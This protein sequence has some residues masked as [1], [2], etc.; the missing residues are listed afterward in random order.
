M[1]SVCITDVQAI[2]GIEDETAGDAGGDNMHLDV[3]RRL[4]A[5]SNC[6]LLMQTLA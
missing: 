4:S 5:G 2:F 1:V 3:T 6:H